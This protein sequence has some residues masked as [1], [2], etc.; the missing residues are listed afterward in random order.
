MAIKKTICSLNFKNIFNFLILFFLLFQS[1]K[2]YLNPTTLEQ[3]TT[4]NEKGYIIITMV[5][6]YEYKYENIEVI[7]GNYYGVYT[8]KSEKITTLLAKDEIKEVKRY[9][10]K[11]SGFFN[12][13][14]ITVGIGSVFLALSMFGG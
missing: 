2:V 6:G 13:L 7:D 12:I 11:S 4:S 9:N 14:G 5:N 8:E 10:K 3:E 1:C